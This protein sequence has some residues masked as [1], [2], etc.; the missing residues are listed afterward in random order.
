MW[1]GAAQPDE[2]QQRSQLG[3]IV[4]ARMGGRP[5]LVRRRQATAGDRRR[6]QATTGDCIDRYE[7]GGVGGCQPV[8]DD[9]DGRIWICVRVADS[10]GG[11]QRLHVHMGQS[12]GL[13]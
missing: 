4:I 9:A 7:C 6:P 2:A 5:D 13:A 3:A 12:V 11:I 10:I 8:E 1:H